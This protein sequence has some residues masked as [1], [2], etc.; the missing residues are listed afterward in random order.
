MKRINGQ[1]IGQNII[2]SSDITLEGEINGGKTLEEVLEEQSSE[3]EKLKSNV[4]WIYKYG[5]VGGKGGGGSSTS[6]S[7]FARLGGEAING[8]TLI[9]SQPD[10]YD[11][12]IRINNPSG[13][14]FRVTYKYFYSGNLQTN[15][16]NLDINNTWTLED[17][18]PLD[19]NNKIYIEVLDENAEIKSIESNYITKSYTL[20]YKLVNDKGLPFSQKTIYLD[21]IR[22]NGF[23]VR[24]KYS[25]ID[26]IDSFS[27]SYTPFGGTDAISDVVTT[28]T[29]EK[30][31]GTVEFDAL[32]YPSNEIEEDFVG[33]FTSNLSISVSGRVS[34]FTKTINIYP[35][36]LFLLIEPVEG[37]IYNKRE[38]DLDNVKKYF[39]GAI[40]F[41]I[42]AYFGDSNFGQKVTYT[43]STAPGD[44]DEPQSIPES[45][46]EQVE[47][48][49]LIERTPIKSVLSFPKNKIG[50]N[51]L[52]FSA[53]SL[54]DS[55]QKTNRYVYIYIDQFN[56][57]LNWY[58]TLLQADKYNTFK[59]FFHFG[60][61]DEQDPGFHIDSER[62][63]KL[64]NII[65][66]T[67][68]S[69]EKTDLYP[70]NVP[71][72]QSPKDCL[73][74]I[75][76]QYN[77][78]SDRDK[79]I[80]ELLYVGNNNN[81]QENVTIGVYQNKIKFGQDAEGEIFLGTELE[82]YDKFN[83]ENYHL[84]SIYRRYVDSKNNTDYFEMC[85][86]IDGVLEAALP[87]YITYSPVYN[88]IRL[89]NNNYFIN[90]LELTYF[91]H[92]SSA[93]YLT[94]TGIVRY[95]Y[96]YKEQVQRIEAT[97]EIIQLLN[98]FEGTVDQGTETIDPG[99]YL[100]DDKYVAVKDNTVISGIVAN[101]N[102]PIMVITYD[103]ANIGSDGSFLAWSEFRYP[104]DSV[105]NNTKTVGIKWASASEN[106]LTNINYG[107]TTFSLAIQGSS[108]KAY[109]S[110]NYTL[111]LNGSSESGH[112]SLFSPNFDP[113]DTNTFLPEQEFTLKA[114]VVDSGHSNNTCMGAFINKATI[115]FADSTLGNG[116]EYPS[117]RY[118]G[119]VKN[120][121]EGFPFLLFL[122]ISH[123]GGDTS[124]TSK[125][126]YY[127][128]GIYNFNLGRKSFFNLGYSDV[129]KLPD[130]TSNKIISKGSFRFC[131]IEG[132]HYNLKKNFTCAEIAFNENWFD[133]SAYDMSILF[134]KNQSDTLFMFDDIETGEENEGNAQ[135]NIAHFVEATTR[136]GGYIFEELKKSFGDHSD[137]YK[138]KGQVPEYAI[139]YEKFIDGDIVFKENEE[140]TREF[141][142]VVQEDLLNYVEAD[143]NNPR[144]TVDYRSLVEY[145]T[146]CMIFGLVDSVQKNLTIKTWDGKKF[147]FAFYDMDTC[148]GVDNG[149]KNSTYYAFSDL[150]E[151]DIE[152]VDGDTVRLRGPVTVHRD[153]F[154]P[155]DDSTIVGYDVPSSYA[156]AVAKYFKSIIP[157]ALRPGYNISPQSLWARWRNKAN[158]VS[159]YGLLPDADYFI[160][161]FYLSYMKDVNELM[162]NYNYRQKYLKK[163]MEIDENQTA[164]G[165]DYRDISKF[166]GRRTEYI[167]EWLTGR[168]HIM[169]AYLNLTNSKVSL[170]PEESDF[171][172]AEQRP[173]GGEVDPDNEDIYVMNDIFYSGT[174]HINQHLSFTVQAPDYSPLVISRGESA[175]RYILQDSEKKYLIN[176]DNTGNNNIILGGSALWTYL[177]SIDGLIFNPMKISSK[178]LKNVKG[179]LG[180]VNSW[181]LNLPA[182]QTLS[183]T[184]PSY[185][186]KIVFDGSSIDSYPNL[187]EI[188]ISNSN[189]TL[190]V[191][192]ESVKTI[193]LN[194]V[195][196]SSNSL[197]SVEIVECHNL[198][199]LF[200]SG[201]RLYQFTV[202][203]VWTNEI[204]LTGN[205][206]KEISLT[207]NRDNAS[208]TI[209]DH[210]LTQLALG[211]FS[212]V[213][214]GVCPQLTRIS[215]SGEN[216]K[217]IIISDSGA[218][219]L[220]EIS[221][222][223]SSKLESLS[224]SGCINL[225]N[226]TLRGGVDNIT[227]LNLSSTSIKGIKYDDSDA[228]PEELDLTRMKS[229]KKLDVSGNPAVE[230]IKVINEP[231]NPVE[232]YAAGRSPGTSGPYSNLKRIYGHF[233]IT[234]PQ[235]F[236]YLHSNFKLLDSDD[237]KWNGVTMDITGKNTNKTPLEIVANLSY[238]N[239]E[240]PTN[241]TN[242]TEDI[243]NKHKAICKVFDSI[244][245]RENLTDTGG[246]VINENTGK[247]E[248]IDTGKSWFIEGTKATNISF[249]KS[250]G[251]G[252]SSNVLQWICAGTPVS[253]FEIYYILNAFAISAARCIK[254]GYS[255][256]DQS[257]FYSFWY[258]DGNK[259]RFQY[260]GAVEKD[261]NRYMFYGC[262]KITSLTAES[263]QSSATATRL[264]PPSHDSEGN[265]ICNNGLFSP[266]DRLSYVGQ[267]ISSSVY[268]N[269][270]LFRRE[271]GTG[272]YPIS[273]FSGFLQK[274]VIY[275][276]VDIRSQYFIQ[277]SGDLAKF[278][279]L[280]GFFDDISGGNLTL[281]NSFS[282]NYFNF[283][284]LTIPNNLKTK[285]VTCCFNSEKGGYGIIDLSNIFKDKTEL[286]KIINSFKISKADKNY[287]RA[288]NDLSSG[289]SIDSEGRALFP[290][291]SGMFDGFIKLQHL[292]ASPNAP[293]TNSNTF[294]SG[295][296]GITTVNSIASEEESLTITGFTGSGLLKYIAQESFPYDLFRPLGENLESCSGFLAE[297]TTYGDSFGSQP[298]ASFEFP[299][300]LFNDGNNTST[301]RSNIN[302]IDV[303]AFLK[304]CEI[305]YTLTGEGFSR[306][307][308]LE[309][310][311]EIFF[312]NVGKGD[313][314]SKLTGSI[315]PKLFYHGSSV[316]STTSSSTYYG[317]DI[318][319]LANEL[320]A[321]SSGNDPYYGNDNHKIVISRKTISYK[322]NITYAYAAFRGCANIIPY[323]SGNINENF[324][325]EDNTKPYIIPVNNNTIDININ[326]KPEYIN[327]NYT[328][329]GWYTDGTKWIKGDTRP[330]D[331]SLV[332][333]GDVET[334][335]ENIKNISTCEENF[336]E[337]KIVGDNKTKIEIFSDN[338]NQK[339][340]NTVNFFC[341]PDLFLY[342]NNNSSTNI[343]YM[344]SYCGL[345]KNT[346]MSFSNF[347]KA[348]TGRICPYL[349]KPISS[350]ESLAG[351]FR[352]CSG[353][354][355]VKYANIDSTQEEIDSLQTYL[356]PPKFFSYARNVSIL[357]G[358]FSGVYFEP[359]PSLNVFSP[360]LT[361]NLDI[362]GIFAW[363]G[364]SP[365][366]IEDGNTISYLFNSISGVF[367]NNSFNRI[368]GAFS[369][370]PIIIKN[371]TGST[372]GVD[373]CHVNSGY[374]SRTF[375][376]DIT[377]T[378]KYPTFGVNFPDSSS[379]RSLLFYTY[380]VYRGHGDN[381]NDNR[382]YDFNTANLNFSLT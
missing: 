313:I 30:K 11:L 78:T 279:D 157:P 80:L 264:L 48:G 32:G 143:P 301:S 297:L 274:G 225:Q 152:S 74:S 168:F 370:C 211:G 299:G 339:Q 205:N 213:N 79:A 267:F 325:K 23:K 37:S 19:S 121:L 212:T 375:R 327:S 244:L 58:P 224:L 362:R 291:K 236:Y 105:E 353:L 200:I 147:Y 171:K 381:A 245:N 8:E 338:N 26:A 182:L 60:I 89:Y 188:D 352:Y 113:T 88:R 115:K 184:S 217:T 6:W 7:I 232:F 59:N 175:L 249:G 347:K 117:D 288:L 246:T 176:V 348:L 354:S 337:E 317:T 43:I 185:S 254:K 227:N 257:L 75:G 324:G 192:K 31:E 210:G 81:V 359:N 364:Y 129:S 12:M 45:S 94:D 25:V 365:Q 56:S 70:D 278:G 382:I 130:P 331:I 350:I 295:Y 1:N 47:S 262:S 219:N 183:L 242:L 107:S 321:G 355:S 287:Q 98:Y 186:G 266:L 118:S 292:G 283:N 320:N 77:Y 173:E 120:C 239:L 379:F 179:T 360:Y 85:V 191:I 126:K 197:P 82:N 334:V 216:I 214:I 40:S 41:F 195:G 95:W 167:R 248:I 369:S 109:A 136:A 263:I 289:G 361:K 141:V 255:V 340:K 305:P 345:P 252:I 342:F 99:V 27:Y 103:E 142:P 90:N 222:E 341:P 169:D 330:L 363:C 177:S 174:Q 318:D 371:N 218:P 112:I 208:L 145:Y 149:G 196:A 102:I 234:K 65:S 5:G 226:L 61:T 265:V 111:K 96:T 275:D 204:N 372:G 83:R 67:I 229:L 150:W 39:P 54:Y 123:P 349:L 284:T 356:I 296:T 181:N 281:Y 140:K 193:I 127:Y 215:I 378:L 162:F 35:K 2:T 269:R 24:I 50:W 62:G 270:F 148:L 207:S 64:V 165:Y 134:K 344:F 259:S 158:L 53:Q 170:N 312:A 233:K 261:P 221:I 110:K 159:G 277:N 63:P 3:I 71:S 201:A 33:S 332:Y 351:L 290:I 311:T 323:S 307:T 178:R 34:N 100:L 13:G 294:I 251:E 328:Y 309:N 93:D 366:K 46:W 368:S 87:N 280:T 160:D 223:D 38:E 124:P 260:S 329:W 258:T 97:N 91:P 154:S 241:S 106:E 10:Q 73:L 22:T 243:K 20:D 272:K 86:Y 9:F 235:A 84:I 17:K 138:V 314:C 68:N 156:F 240:P 108:S 28:D 282:L 247:E 300:S 316:S 122:E 256:A 220:T 268:T 250:D 135:E 203:P 131:E 310:I 377:P 293:Y 76:I 206:I 306:C 55:T 189:I 52:K 357:A 276:E 92:S 104:E 376:T 209:S 367:T 322:K 358:T 335:S 14:V 304:N 199:K 231:D 319:P 119:F 271:A 172:Y 286:T 51:I 49:T 302:L 144:Y 333:D 146:I 163:T 69:K 29:E 116:G 151:N 153:Y 190:N 114:D 128:L 42:T 303:A 238:S 346:D 21:D 164:F 4:K 166:H 285:E 57:D 139:Y 101:S 343:Q 187:E 132:G 308:N 36:N 16:V 194:G 253:Q 273:T 18:I 198:S 72:S 66:Q 133:F 237:N 326:I 180:T 336:N 125:N 44:T 315:P 380:Y 137:G 155:T 15:T 373:F 374:T 202:T 298:N 230:I 161:N 228:I